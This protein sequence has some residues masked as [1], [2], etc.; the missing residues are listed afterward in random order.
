MSQFSTWTHPTTGQVRVYISGFGATKVWAEQCE[1]D[2]FGFDY[3]IR[4]VNQM[5]NRSELGNIINDAE[6]AIFEA[7][8]SRIKDFD[9]VVGLAK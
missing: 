3:T 2:Q 8:Q 1:K 5:R 9:S 6:R 4:A 7:A